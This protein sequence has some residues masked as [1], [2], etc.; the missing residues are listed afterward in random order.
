MAQ[1]VLHFPS[2]CNKMTFIAHLRLCPFR[3][4]G[5]SLVS[6]NKLHYI[7]LHTD[8]SF[9][10]NAR[11]LKIKQERIKVSEFQ[12]VLYWKGYKRER[13][14]IT[15][16]VTYVILTSHYALSTVCKCC[17]HTVWDGIVVSMW[18]PDVQNLKW[19]GTKTRGR[20]REGVSWNY[21]ASPQSSGSLA[22]PIIWS[23]P[24]FLALLL[25]NPTWIAETST[26]HQCKPKALLK[27]MLCL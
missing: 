21:W 20:H 27:L 7:S 15:S 5:H 2:G 17:A 13:A 8:G 1:S 24:R 18:V 10:H 16:V 6:G 25:D 26:V 22:G 12:N 14:C 4:M 11:E 9:L 19:T 3:I 23:P